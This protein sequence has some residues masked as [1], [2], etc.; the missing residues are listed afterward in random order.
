MFGIGL[1]ELIVIMALA[2]IVIG[3]DKLP[4]MAPLTGQNGDGSKKNGCYPA[5]RVDQ[6]K[7]TG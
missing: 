7:S 3:P 5:G 6:G 1:P 2:L 4:E